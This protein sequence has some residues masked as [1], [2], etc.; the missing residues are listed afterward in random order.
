MRNPGL[1]LFVLIFSALGD[2]VENPIAAQEVAV[3]DIP[4]GKF[5]MGNDTGPIWDQ[6][7]AHPV[8][9]TQAFRISVT[10][11]TLEQFQAFCPGWRCASADGLVRGVRWHDAVAY[12]QWLSNATG[13]EWRLPT[14][15]EW[16]Y[17]CRSAGVFGVRN[18]TNEVREWCMD[19]YGP[20]GADAAVNPPGAA[21]GQARVVR[22]GVLDWLDGKFECLPVSEYSQP[23]YRAGAAPGF[24]LVYGGGTP[25]HYEDGALPGAHNIGFRVVEAAAP[26]AP[27]APR[28]T[29]FMQLGVKDTL[30][31]AL[32]GPAPDQPY[33]RK[34]PLLPTPPESE[35]N[36]AK[37]AEFQ[38]CI[39]A[40]GLHPSFR[41]HNHSPA[42]EVCDNG[43]V[44]LSI[45]T[46]YSEYEPEMSL[47]GSR[48]RFGADAW[49][50]PSPMV[51][52]PGFCDNTPLLWK[53]QGNV[54]L[55]WAWTRAEG[56]FPFQWVVSRDHG[57]TWS[58]VRFPNFTGRIGPH[59]KQPINRAFRAMDGTVYVPSDAVGGSSVLWASKDNLK[60][61]LD[62]RGRSAGRHTVY[63]E[64][65]DA[66]ILALGGKNT[67]IEG[68]MPKAISSDGGKTWQVSKS[69]F[70]A[71]AVNQRP[72]LIRLQSGRLFYAGDYQKWEGVRP[73]DATD[74]GSF[75]AL[76]ED[77]G[78]TW[79]RKKLPGAQEHENGPRFFKGLPGA[80]TL[81]YSV[82]RQAPNG[83]IHLITTMN[84]PSLH[85]EM[86][87]AW[88]L[89]EE[90]LAPGEERITANTAQKIRNIRQYR[91]T[92]PDGSTKHV[93]HAGMGDDG[94]YLLHGR[95][96]WFFPNGQKQY[97]ARHAL[98]CKTGRE[99]LWRSDGKKQW[100]WEHTGDGLSQWT[101]WW[102]N[103]S[104]KAE[105]QWKSFCAVGMARTW[106]RSGAL[107]T[108]M[109]M[110]ER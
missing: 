26:S 15:A 31:V 29:P 106:D 109:D 13:K 63:C 12:C 108:E 99:T 85:F 64:L 79:R 36:R 40:A 66:S 81:G 90:G 110:D 100:E 89:S 62:T 50:M 2:A 46:S 57:A 74:A 68:Y 86:N 93:W 9:I 72:S 30:P 25:G 10:E 44:L 58:E 78:V 45:F 32:Q 67:D 42:L 87:E 69:S 49:D 102:D 53:D 6:K 88:I 60:T 76:S 20:Y 80:T 37:M 23:A 41:G 77:D 18:M 96:T 71:L 107:S 39:D 4:A 35:P 54:Y 70:P 19:W 105:S 75:V 28:E 34:R 51:D 104:R 97:S 59:S 48:L 8:E 21:S 55:F 47:M 83:V 52:F 24:G 16:D 43:D 91:E 5:I 95:E 3:A 1:I 17:V 11:I 33:F 73:A 103:G 84:R 61:W 101:Q 38:K 92:Y 7:P 14:E 27:Q 22:G 98:G 94:R 65:K 82:A 56:G